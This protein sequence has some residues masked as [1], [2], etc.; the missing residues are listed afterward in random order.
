M[1]GNRRELPKK[2]P[3][4]NCNYMDILTTSYR[5]LI[6]VTGED[7]QYHLTNSIHLLHA[8]Y[9]LKTYKLQT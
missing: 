7:N 3:I 6:L 4:K 5:R 2:A 1:S 8:F 9:H